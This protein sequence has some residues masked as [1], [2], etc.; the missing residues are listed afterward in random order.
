MLRRKQKEEE[1]A[2]ETPRPIIGFRGAHVFDV[3]QTDGEPLPSLQPRKAIQATILDRLRRILGG[4]GIVLERSE[5]I[6]PA[7]G[8]S[9]GGKITLL[10]SLDPADTFAVVVHEVAHELLHQSERRTQTTNTIRETEAEAVAFVVSSAV[11]LD[12]NSASSDYIQ[13]YSGDKATLAE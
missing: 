12:T 8:M 11:G 10:P 9:S 5:R 3:S 6:L 1:R 2:E 7:K 13:L 4:K